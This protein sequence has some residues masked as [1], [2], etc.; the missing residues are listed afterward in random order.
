MAFLYQS[1]NWKVDDIRT[2]ETGEAIAY[3]RACVVLSAS[4]TI[5]KTTADTDVA[6][7]LL[8]VDRD[9]PASGVQAEYITRGDLVFVAGGAISIGD[10][11][12]PDD[13]TAGRMRTAVSGD[14]IFGTAL[15]ESAQAG[16][17]CL[18]RFDF[19]NSSLLA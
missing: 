15:E 7:G 5:I 6:L 3:D 12:C 16:D 18:G 17:F 14:R 8:K 2:A 13:G 9:T 19:N 10:P 11:L 4:R 1:E